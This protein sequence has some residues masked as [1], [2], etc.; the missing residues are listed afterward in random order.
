MTKPGRH[1]TVEHHP[2]RAR[3]D[4]MLDDGVTYEQIVRTVGGVSLSAVGRYALSRKSELE[5]LAEGEP[6]VTGILARL[7]EAADHAHDLR[8][9]SKLSGSPVA[10]NRAIKGEIEVLA[11]LMGE[12]GVSDTSVTDAI[13][14]SDAV[15]TALK[16]FVR[17]YPDSGADLL[18]VLTEN[19]TTRPLAQAF[20]R[21]QI[22]E[23]N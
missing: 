22:I 18:K 16:V 11:K 13:R 20:K 12:L 3:I 5:K 17:T 21:V 8:T 2:L 19:P 14:E 7:V 10:Q 4:L 6:G 1:S 9:R 15:V 23:K